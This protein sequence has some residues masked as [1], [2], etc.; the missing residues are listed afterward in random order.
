MSFILEDITFQLGRYTKA[1]FDTGNIPKTNWDNIFNGYRNNKPF[2]VFTEY[3]FKQDI[4][5]VN[6]P[7]EL[8]DYKNRV[9]IHKG[10]NN[11]F[12]K[13]GQIIVLKRKDGDKNITK[14]FFIWISYSLWEKFLTKKEGDFEINIHINFH[15]V[16]PIGKKYPPYYN[17][18]QDSNILNIDDKNHPFYLKSR[19][20]EKAD[21]YGWYDQNFF[22]LGVR[23]L[24]KEKQSILQHRC[25]ILRTDSDPNNLL[26]SDKDTIP[27]MLIVPVSSVTPYFGDFSKASDFKE[28]IEAISHKCFDL[29]QKISNIP[30]KKYPSIKRVACSFYSRSGEVAEQI[31]LNSP[32]FINEFYLYDIVLDRKIPLRTKKEGF[33]KLWNLLKKWKNNN[34]NKIRIYSSELDTV[35]AIAEELRKRPHEEHLANF[36]SFNNKPDRNNKPD[37][38]KKTG[39]YLNL[40][41]GYEIYRD[42]KSI[43][44]VVVPNK[45]FFHY[46]EEMGNPNGFYVD[47]NY[48]LKGDQGHSW[49]VSRLQ[50]HSIF[51]SGFKR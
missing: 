19:T 18:A 33:D 24:F 47:D 40:S 14:Y 5:K 31:L 23:Y 34:D 46:L 8:F 11:D 7:V 43:S 32:N 9:G 12:H 35:M 51:H 4:S 20:S 10:S 27:I 39:I 26:N 21:D 22:E 50:S 41:P 36:S 28:I 37:I 6:F 44:L 49:F 16:G 25:S 2:T 3:I 15:P 38:N 29:A 30:L 42:E 17:E 13:H 48:D 1:Y 45:N